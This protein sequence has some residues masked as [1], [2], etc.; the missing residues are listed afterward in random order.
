V[1]RVLLSLSDSLQV[2]TLVAV[3]GYAPFC[4]R[5]RRAFWV[6]FLLVGIWGFLRIFAVVKFREEDV[7]PMIGFLVA[8]FLWGV[9]GLV[10]RGI[11]V[12]LCAYSRRLEGFNDWVQERFGAKLGGLAKRR[13][14]QD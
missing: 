14:S 1:H 3:I 6:P 8:P 10:V 5:S 13:E 11:W 4:L 2:I 12:V 7:P 9:I